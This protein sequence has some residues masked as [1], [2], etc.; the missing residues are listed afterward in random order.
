MLGGQS[1]A[2]LYV[3]QLEPSSTPNDIQYTVGQES[4]TRYWDPD[5]G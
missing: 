5:S 2:V 3:Q 4:L 1:R